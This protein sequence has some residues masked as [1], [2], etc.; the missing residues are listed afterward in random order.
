MTAA[1]IKET[2]TTMNIQ[3]HQISNNGLVLTFQD[4]SEGVISLDSFN[5]ALFDKA[6]EWRDIACV[7][8]DDKAEEWRDIA[9]V[10]Q[11]RMGGKKGWP[12]VQAFIRRYGPKYQLSFLKGWVAVIGVEVSC[13]SNAA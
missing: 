2:P 9:C 6:E 4:G 7:I 8:Q 11:D 3:K 1:P 10:I 13:I 5:S 12:Y